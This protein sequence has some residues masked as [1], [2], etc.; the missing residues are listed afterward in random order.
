MNL[1]EW[2]FP[3]ALAMSITFFVQYFMGPEYN[4]A[5]KDNGVSGQSF[6]AP[7][8]QQ[9]QKPLLLDFD[10]KSKE[11]VTEDRH[12]VKTGL[13]TYVFSS[14][15]A[16]LESLEFV[17]QQGSKNVEMVQGSQNCFLLGL[18]EE[19][20]LNYRFEGESKFKDGVVVTY[21]AEY[22]QGDIVKAFTVYDNSY[23]VDLK[24]SIDSGSKKQ[25]S[26]EQ[27]RLLLP[28]PMSLDDDLKAFKNKATSKQGVAL[29]DID[30]AKQ[31]KEFVF[32]PKAFGFTS[33]FVLQ[34]FVKSVDGEYPL[35]GY[36]KPVTGKQYDA[37][38]E[39]KPFDQVQKINWS[40][41]FGPKT[42]ASL[43]AVD[44]YLIQTLDYGWLTFIA[45]PMLLMLNM[46]KDKLGSYGWAIILLTLLLKLLLLPFT[47]RGEKSM[48]QQAEMQKKLAYVR[49]KYKND[50]A[51]LD[52]ATA[53]LIKKHGVPGFSGCL[54]MLLNIPFF[55]S[56]QRILSSSIE[57]YGASFLWMSD[58]SVA[59]PYYIL[60]VLTGVCMLFTPM[61]N[62]S[63][64]AAM[65][66]GM[67]MFLGTITLYFPAGLALFIFMNTLTS[68]FQSLITKSKVVSRVIG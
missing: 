19:A 64:Q 24:V 3:L 63:K 21:K 39:S 35:R 42:E 28:M 38:L 65:R 30:L 9:A 32:E 15:G 61:G 36:F 59:D 54:P 18:S 17:W 6:V 60:G 46:L 26:A 57:L 10:L 7:D 48:R 51:A 13:A 4:T 33:K 56:L 40:F 5:K 58:L 50:K 27:I 25:G 14:K 45:K 29:Q 12:I 55:V 31:S 49:Q 8:L 43:K 34:S 62:D 20:P 44:P 52:A 11:E 37:I 2:F 22:K 23:Q 66:V 1:K 41:Y 47:L 16:I 53:E 67:A 68:L